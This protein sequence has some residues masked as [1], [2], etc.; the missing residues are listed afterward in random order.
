M[1]RSGHSVTTRISGSHS[2]AC[3]QN[4]GWYFTSTISALPTTIAP[5]N[6]MMN[7]AGPSPASMKA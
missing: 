7:T 3:T 1:A 2:I 6:R 4:G 5:A